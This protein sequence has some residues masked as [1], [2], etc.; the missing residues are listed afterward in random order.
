MALTPC[1][2]GGGGERASAWCSVSLPLSLVF[3]NP[4][5]GDR[6]EVS[7]CTLTT[8]HT[9]RGTGAGL[10]VRARPFQLW[11]ERFLHERGV[12]EGELE[13]QSKPGVGNYFG[14]RATL[15]FRS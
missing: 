7:G 10:A 5:V 14:G 1:V 8:P 9:H 11:M 12:K 4:L 13:R 6:A 15:S 3:S 2:V